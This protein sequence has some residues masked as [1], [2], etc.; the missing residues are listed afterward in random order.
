MIDFVIAFA[1]D[2]TG[3]GIVESGFL[4]GLVSVAAIAVLA[5]FGK[6]VVAMFQEINDSIVPPF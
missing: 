1:K 2:E 6:K 4:I 3:Q 5:V